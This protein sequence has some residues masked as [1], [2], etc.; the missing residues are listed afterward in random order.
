[1]GSLLELLTCRVLPAFLDLADLAQGNLGRFMTL[2]YLLWSFL[3]ILLICP[4]SSELSLV[5]RRFAFHVISYR[6]SYIPDRLS[7]V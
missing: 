4:M 5:S 7:H 6:I 2:W 3:L 1:M